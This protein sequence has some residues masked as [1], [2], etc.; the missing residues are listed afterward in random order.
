M[1]VDSFADAQAWYDR[2]QS[3]IADYRSMAYSEDD[4]IWTIHS[5][6]LPDGKVS[7]KLRFNR[8][9]LVRLKP[10]ACEAASALFQALDNIV[11]VAARDVGIAREDSRAISWPWGLADVP[12]PNAPRPVTLS[13]D[14]KM[15]ELDKIGVPAP[16]LDV[17]R[18]TFAQHVGG[19]VH[20]DVVK[21]V[22]LSGKHWELIRT[23][24]GTNAL[25]WTLPGATQQT[26]AEIPPD[27]FDTEDE[28]AFYEGAPI[29][30]PLLIM[31]KTRLSA[32]GRLFEP[33]PTSAFGYASRF[34][35]TALE[36]ARALWLETRTAHEASAEASA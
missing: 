5:R 16:W 3:H 10:V 20:I 12:D 4:R 7:Y 11:S 34:V 8:D 27:H 22:S 32:P 26:H 28:Y 36:K 21:E 15:R 30:V 24:G 2:A 23:T 19:L 18:E 35:E 29:N 13:I 6:N 1:T 9:L 33:E 25:A 17:I 31:T 14:K